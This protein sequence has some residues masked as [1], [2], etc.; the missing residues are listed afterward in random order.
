V[1]CAQILGYLGRYREAAPLLLGIEAAE[2]KFTL[3]HIKALRTRAEIELGQNHYSQAASAA[4]QAVA[5]DSGQDPMTTSSL[6]QLL[7]LALIGAGNKREGLTY[8]REAFASAAKADDPA[9]KVDRQVGLLRALLAA[10]G[11]AE[12]LQQFES[13]RQALVDRPETNWRV[14][15]SMARIDSQYAGPARQALETLRK[16]WGEEALRSYLSRPDLQTISRDNQ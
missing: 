12:A 8:C 2:S 3:L 5:A 4:K 14:L 16:L 6:H 7:G 9:S 15:A 13:L 11:R 1:Q 10:G